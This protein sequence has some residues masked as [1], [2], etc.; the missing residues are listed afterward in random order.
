MVKAKRHK[1]WYAVLKS[2]S[3]GREEKVHL[4]RLG[5]RD[6]N[7]P[8]PSDRQGQYERDYD[9][10]NLAPAVV[11]RSAHSNAQ[12]KGLSKAPNAKRWEPERESLE[13][14]ESIRASSAGANANLKAASTPHGKTTANT[15][16]A[17]S[18]FDRYKE[19]KK[20]EF[21]E[22]RDLKKPSL[23]TKKANKYGRTPGGGQETSEDI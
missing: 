5:I 23:R 13:R 17:S 7:V 2:Y 8:K 10:G 19:P 18:I 4:G 3:K 20:S 6:M 12:N 15:K 1:V 16:P 22:D 14:R 11:D 21:V 9:P